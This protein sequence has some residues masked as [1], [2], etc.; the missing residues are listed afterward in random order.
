MVSGAAVT[1]TE[2]ADG[3]CAG[4]ASGT[5][6]CPRTSGTETGGARSAGVWVW[7]GAG[8]FGGGAFGA[9][10]NFAAL[11]FGSSA[12]VGKGRAGAAG[13]AL[14]TPLRET[15]ALALYTRLPKSIALI[16]RVVKYCLWPI[17]L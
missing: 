8:S 16:F 9:S 15:V 17:V 12:F 10:T 2:G 11:G 3:G 14:G 13:F 5:A 4:A 1:G 7:V 6:S